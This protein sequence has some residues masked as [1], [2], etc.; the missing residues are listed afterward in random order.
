[1][2]R[3]R[4][5]WLSQAML[6][7]LL[8]H[9]VLSGSYLMCP[10][11]SNKWLCFPE[12]KP[13]PLGTVCKLSP[14]V[15][16]LRTWRSQN[17]AF[18]SCTLSE[19]VFFATSAAPH[20]LLLDCTLRMEKGSR[21]LK[22]ALWSFVEAVTGS[23]PTPDSLTSL[24]MLGITSPHQYPRLQL[25]QPLTWLPGMDAGDVIFNPWFSSLLKMQRCPSASCVLTLRDIAITQWFLWFWSKAKV[26]WEISILVY[27]QI[28][29]NF[30][31]TF[32][33]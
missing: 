7:S 6:S 12:V 4:Y 27:T 23:H 18:E 26:A 19:P 17:T 29:Y 13:V 32:K 9:G 8:K 14:A 24:V 30:F 28:N 10:N 33:T 2:I 3:E 5:S 1:M 16:A 20:S 15:H 31:L 22:S 11:S 21:L 25:S